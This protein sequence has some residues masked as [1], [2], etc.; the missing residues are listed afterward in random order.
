MFSST[1]RRLARLPEVA[2]KRIDVQRVLA[3]RRG[4]RRAG[5]DLGLDLQ[6]Q[7]LHGRV[8][9][10]LADDVERLQQR[11]AGLHHR[12]ELPREQREI[13][14]GDPAA[15]ADLLLLD[16]L[17]QDALPP[18]G[19][20]RKSTRLNSSHLV[21]SYAVFCLKKKKKYEIHSS[22]R[23]RPKFQSHFVVDTSG[24]V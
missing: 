4:E 14:F 24:L 20:D 6:Q 21:I 2:V 5:L 10:A 12:R 8:G 9:G 22:L 13:L 15:A 1:P 18:Q 11:H 7:L 19:G 17:H 3:E 16:L 23:H